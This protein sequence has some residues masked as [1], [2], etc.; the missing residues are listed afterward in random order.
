MSRTKFP[1]K[2]LENNLVFNHDG[3]CYAYYELIPYNYSF[4][5]PEQKMQ[6]NDSFRQLVTKNREGKIHAL[7]IA[8]ESSMRAVQE[9]AKKDIRGN[10]K[11]AALKRLEEQTNIL[12]KELGDNQ[13]DYRYFL[14]FK[15]MVTE[16]EI[17]LSSIKKSVYLTLKEFLNE[18]NHMLMGDFTSMDDEE[19]RRFS[20]VENLL[21]SK[22]SSRF[23][24]RRLTEDDL[25]YVIE[26]HFGKCSV[27]YERYRNPLPKQH[28][29]RRT[30][31]KR[32]DVLR[33][34]KSLVTERQKYLKLESE[35]K[36]TYVTYFTIESVVGELEF[37]SSEIFYYQQS[38]FAFPTDTSM[39][40]EIVPNKKAL[41]T[42]RNKKKELKDLDD[43]AV[44]SGSESS[45]TVLDALDTVDELEGTLDRTKESMYKL[46][47]VIRVW[48]DDLDELSRRCNEIRDFYDDNGIRVVR[49][50]GDMSGLHSEFI[51]SGKRYINDYIQYVTSD[52]LSSLG[53]G[54]TQM[55]GE[56]NGDY[57]GYNVETDR[58]VY[59]KPSL[60][61]RGVSGSVTNSPAVAFVGTTGA[62]KSMCS[63]K[64]VVSAVR[65]GAHALV[66][67]PKSERGNWKEDL[68]ELGDELN[69][70]NI[71]SAEENR[72]LLDP[73]VILKN[74]NDSEKLALDVSTFLLDVTIH[75]GEEFSALQDAVKAVGKRKKRGL[76]LVIDELRNQKTPTAER[77]AKHMESI[78]SYD[79]AHLL[80]SN[81][82]VT[83]S[84]SLEKQLNIIQV[85]DLVLPE[86]GTEVK[87]YGLPE[88]LSVAMMIVISTFALD[89]IHSDRS[90]FKIVDL[91]EAWAILNTPQGK[92][93]VNRLV[94][95]GRSMNAGVYFVTQSAGD[96]P[97]E[98]IR[99][100]IGLKFAFRSTDMD[101]IKATLEFFGLDPDDRENQSRIMNL[102]NGE[103]LFQDLYGRTGVIK[104][105]LVFD[106]EFY[107]FDTRPPEQSEVEV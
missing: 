43:N 107:A 68:P 84:I 59:I 46:S 4:L 71:T 3:E 25:G 90:V 99:N 57:L 69:I 72:G 45:D 76:L 12:V 54:A 81:G 91:D 104:I 24:I 78:A 32:Y 85:A 36:K 62:G 10:L 87:D 31:V 95:A 27:P 103:C 16:E 89:F 29:D 77:L 41:H 40:V 80:F 7:Q 94:R 42:V 11:E 74:K 17:S 2:Y 52:F 35:E 65:N 44:T 70:V 21:E 86:K 34:G 20:K 13:I 30:L 39:Q 61:A 26:H 23:R 58:P 6:I 51:P 53:F 64:V 47:Y 67:D 15:L 102:E 106:D 33:L 75:M 63:N 79:F 5:S 50:F 8:T 9:R 66:L 38:Q 73:F 93:L 14:G 55:L 60:A 100:N 1:V 97:D 18:V 48:A 98:K 22:I 105:D 19:I 92:I 82:E 49:P 101:E 37:P 28:V 88:M 56:T 96:I 83:R